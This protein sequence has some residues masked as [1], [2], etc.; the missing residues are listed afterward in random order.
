M[1]T[2]SSLG[3]VALGGALGAVARYAFALAVAARFPAARFPVATLAINVSGCFVIALF[4][5]TAATRHAHDPLRLLV[6]IGFV[7]AY[8]TFS[9]YEWELWQLGGQRAWGAAVL[10]AIC[11]NVLGLGAVALGAAIGKRL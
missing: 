6:P 3:L 8:T 9:T 1:T 2:L 7:G 5:S 11:S 10:Y 4:L